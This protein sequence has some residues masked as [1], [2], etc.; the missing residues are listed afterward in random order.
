[1]AFQVQ[2]TKE[3]GFFTYGFNSQ[4]LESHVSNPTLTKSTLTKKTVFGLV[5]LLFSFFGIMT[6]FF[7]GG[8]NC[9][10]DVD[11]EFVGGSVNGSV[12]LS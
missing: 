11:S 9:D 10:D 4:L 7:V 1:M 8:K 6:I 3:S 2:P 12:N 5:L